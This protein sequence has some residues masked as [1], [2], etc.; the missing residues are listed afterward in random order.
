MI[1]WYLALNWKDVEGS[2]HGLT[3]DTF[4]TFAWRD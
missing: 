3:Y 1:G 2:E 4:P